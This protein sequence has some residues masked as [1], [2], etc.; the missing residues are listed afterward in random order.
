MSIIIELGLG[1]LKVVQCSVYYVASKR[2][3]IT[4]VVCYNKRGRSKFKHLLKANIN[5]D[6]VAS[7]SNSIL[8]SSSS[9]CELTVC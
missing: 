6:V 9:S 5:N 2:A 8:S 4:S 3:V 1:L 7:V